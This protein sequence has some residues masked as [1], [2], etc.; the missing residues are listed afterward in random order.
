MFQILSRVPIK[1]WAKLTLILFYE[2]HNLFF[3]GS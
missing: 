1:L 2:G 3:I